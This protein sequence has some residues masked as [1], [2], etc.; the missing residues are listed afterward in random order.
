MGII[1]NWWEE[2]FHEIRITRK[3]LMDKILDQN[4]EKPYIPTLLNIVWSISKGQGGDEWN[5]PTKKKER[6]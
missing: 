4:L 2:W 6:K 1:E 3:D 5:D